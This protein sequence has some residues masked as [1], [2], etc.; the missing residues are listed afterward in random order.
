[1]AKLHLPAL[2][3]CFPFYFLLSQDQIL[4]TE[5]NLEIIS[6]RI[7]SANVKASEQNSKKLAHQRTAHCVRLKIL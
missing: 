4:M 7:I 2:H 6:R 5:I 1:M 3:L